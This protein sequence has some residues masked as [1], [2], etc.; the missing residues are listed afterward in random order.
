MLVALLGLPCWPSLVAEE[1][2]GRRAPTLQ[3]IGTALHSVEGA[4]L[5]AALDPACGVP[6]P[7][8]AEELAP[9]RIDAS[10]GASAFNGTGSFSVDD[11]RGTE[12]CF[13]LVAPLSLLHGNKTLPVVICAPRPHAL[14]K[15]HLL[16]CRRHIARARHAALSSHMPNTC[17]R[18]ATGFHGF[19]D[20]ANVVSGVIGESNGQEH[21]CGFRG[22]NAHRSLASLALGGTSQFALVCPEA[23]RFSGQP[24][25]VQPSN[26]SW[27]MDLVTV[28]EIPEKMSTKQVRAREALL[29]DPN[30]AAM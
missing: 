22:D 9:G 7:L 25:V 13:S 10:A 30:P 1:R 26:S 2:L 29:G 14:L 17:A 12:R 16:G 15:P 21:G 27:G 11:A 18:P 4:K 3:P 23:L 20:D 5:G 6:V 28:W 24:D 8:G 19:T